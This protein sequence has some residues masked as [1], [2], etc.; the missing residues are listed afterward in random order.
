MQDNHNQYTMQ[1][2]LDQYTMQDTHFQYTM[3]DAAL[4]MYISLFFCLFFVF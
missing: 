2:K 1:D 4:M 3:Q